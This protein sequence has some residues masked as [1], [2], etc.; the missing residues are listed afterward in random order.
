MGY[1]GYCE[2]MGVT[3]R[4]PARRRSW[5]VRGL[6]AALITVLWLQVITAIL[7]HSPSVAGSR[8]PAVLGGLV[9]G[10]VLSVILLWAFYRPGRRLLTELIRSGSVPTAIYS[11]DRLKEALQDLTG[12]RLKSYLSRDGAF[13]AFVDTGEKFELWRWY[14]N[15]PQCVARIPWSRTDSY[16]Q[17][18]V[19]HAVTIDRAIV[20]GLQKS[21]QRVSIPLTPYKR[22]WLR[23]RPVSDEEFWSLL[24]HFES[25]LS[26]DGSGGES[27]SQSIVSR[28]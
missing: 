20:V 3:A 7:G 28:N 15:R 10:A 26:G 11:S 1:H 8:L 17:D 14:W 23:L 19:R 12:V 5:A 6:L 22:G 21:G 4:I 13:L 24:Q 2:Q 9:G 18:E 25:H 27:S 16:E